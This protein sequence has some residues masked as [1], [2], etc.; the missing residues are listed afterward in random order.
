MMTT[1][2][3]VGLKAMI[4][5]GCVRDKEGCLELGLPVFARGFLPRGPLKLDFGGVNR[6]VKCGGVNVNPGDLIIADADGI[7]VAPR[8]RVYEIL[9]AAEKKLRYDNDRK[10]LMAE[11]EKA[12][13]AGQKL[14][15]IAP[16]WVNDIIGN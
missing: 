6:S 4:V 15:E 2:K 7:A 14:L 3:V 5:D 16:K 1:G 9:D 12:R 11:Y 13:M 8:E 10:V